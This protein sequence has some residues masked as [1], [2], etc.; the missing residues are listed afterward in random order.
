MINENGIV[1]PETFEEALSHFTKGPLVFDVET[2]GLNVMYGDKICGI[3]VCNMDGK[4]YYFPVRHTEGVNLPM[5]QYQKLIYTIAKS[6]ILINQNIKF[7]LKALMREGVP[8]DRSWTLIDLQVMARLAVSDRTVRVALDKT[9]SRYFGDEESEYKGSVK[10]WLKKN[11]KKKFSEAPIDLVGV[12]CIQDVVKTYK[13][14]KH[15]WKE[16]ISLNQT[17]I[18]NFEMNTTSDL[19]KI[20]FTGV[21]FDRE[22]CKR[23]ISL[24]RN[25]MADL[26]KQAYD[27]AGKVFNVG[28]TKQINEIFDSIG[29]PPVYYTDKGNPKWD[30]VAL[31]LTDHELAK[32]LLNWRSL[33]KLDST[34]FSPLLDL[35]CDYIYCSFTN[36]RAITGR[37][38]SREPNLQNIPRTTQKLDEI[39]LFSDEGDQERIKFAKQWAERG[40]KSGKAKSR[41]Q[42]WEIYEDFDESRDDIIAGRRLFIPRE[43]HQLFAMDFS[44][45]EMIVFLS[46]INSPRI[47][48]MIADRNFDIH[49]YIAKEAYGVDKTNPDFKFFRQVSKE[50]SY[51]IIYGMGLETLAAQMGTEVKKAKEF[52]NKYFEIIPEAKQFLKDVAAKVESGSAIHNRYGRQYYID[53][54]KSY[55]GVNYLV[56]GTSAEIVKER[57]HLM[58]DFLEN[59]KSKLLIQVH[60]EF[61]FDIHK[62]D[63]AILPTIKTMLEENSIGIPLKMEVSECCPSWIQKKKIEDIDEYAKRRVAEMQAVQAVVQ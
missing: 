6:N 45:M 53:P 42:T 18:W 51:G 38:S 61:I 39:S 52:R 24:L 40:L 15:L 41:R 27:I 19:L 7:D 8:Y 37:L 62:D 36:W 22:Y 50:I 4:A 9:L 20:E 32:I 48:A 16:L 31:F 25:R 26:E 58:I 1:T 46:Y 47:K 14:F 60:D 12:Y 10:E 43:E 34:Y 2:E 13:L 56:Q 29:I 21:K 3:G 54:A 17:K 28:S 44:Q 33:A 30:S 57:M 23:G 49:T 63:Y 5:P 55:L 11:K 35:P 59:T